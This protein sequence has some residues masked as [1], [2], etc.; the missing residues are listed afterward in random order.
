[1]EIIL[2]GGA[3][4]SEIQTAFEC[5]LQKSRSFIS[6]LDESCYQGNVRARKGESRLLSNVRS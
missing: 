5:E 6:M 2:D 3:A 4:G 1:M